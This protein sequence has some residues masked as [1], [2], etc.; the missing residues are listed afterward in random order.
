MANRKYQCKLKADKIRITDKIYIKIPTVSEVLDNEPT[1]YSI[2]YN[3]TSSPYQQM[4]HLDD[5]GIDYSKISEWELFLQTFYSYSASITQSKENIEELSKVLKE[6]TIDD[7]EKIKAVNEIQNLNDYIED[8][9]NGFE[10]VFGDLQI[11]G[12]NIYKDTNLNETI[13]YN[14]STD[15]RIDKL[16]YLEISKT[17]R[18]INLYEHVKA[19][20]GNENAKKYLLD[21]ERKK[22]KRAA[23]KPYEPYLEKLVIALVNTSEFPYNYET[24]MDL[25][26]YNFNQSFKQ[27]QHKIEF[28]NTMIGVY[29]GTVN[30]EKMTDKSALSWIQSK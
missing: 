6:D 21:R 24:C 1:Y 12:F 19:K 13:L 27:I 9:L 5:M 23:R 28:D 7:A 16:T 8:T 17:I 2:T 4:V 25:S 3:L 20:P 18:D 22:L 26:L 14:K 15:T 30:T 10:L 11:E 29:A